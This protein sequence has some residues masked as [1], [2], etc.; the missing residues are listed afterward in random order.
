MKTLWAL[1]SIQ[2]AL[3]VILILCFAHAAVGRISESF[4]VQSASSQYHYCFLIRATSDDAITKY[5]PAEKRVIST[6]IPGKR[7]YR[8]DDGN[9]RTSDESDALHS[10]SN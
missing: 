8:C 5:S 4:T 7:L 2:I 9:L 6:F 10:D 1:L 3:F